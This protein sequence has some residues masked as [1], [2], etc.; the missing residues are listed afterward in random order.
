MTLQ[1][2]QSGSTRTAYCLLGLLILAIT[3]AR[4]SSRLLLGPVAHHTDL[5]LP[6][7]LASRINHL[8]LYLLL[9]A[10]PLLGWAQ[11]SARAHQFDIFGLA[12]PRLIQRDPDV[13][14]ILSAWHDWLAWVLLAL[15]LIHSLA[16][17]YHHYVRR[18]DVLRTM[19]PKGGSSYAESG[20]SEGLRDGHDHSGSA[21][22]V[23]MAHLTSH[24]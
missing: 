8:L 17:L 18:D 10:M 13:A 1:S 16:A 11:S 19:L 24:R 21:R 14:D 4:L 22:L 23:P 20:S 6:M 2:V 3:L 7:W 9:M 5:P 12:I 15:I